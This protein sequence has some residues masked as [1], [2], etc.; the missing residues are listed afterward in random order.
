MLAARWI[1]GYNLRCV[2]RLALHILFFLSG[3]AALGYQLIWAK[4]FSTGLGHEYP[5]VLAIVCAFMV[6]M[7]LG[8]ATIDRFVPRDARAQWALA[9]LELIVGLWAVLA[10]FLI[11]H[12]NDWAPQ[13]IGLQPSALKHWLIAFAV[14]AVTLLPA[15]FSMGATLPVM[16]KLLSVTVDR[17]GSIGSIYAA[18]TFGAVLGTLLAPWLLMPALGFTKSCWVL[19]GLNVLVSAGVLALKVQR[20]A[21]TVPTAH[22][23]AESPVLTPRRITLTLFVAGLLGIS[24]EV[25][26]V[27][28]LSQ[29]MENTVYTYASIL[30]IF[31]LGTAAGAAAF[32]RW[33]RGMNPER[34]L[35]ALLI[36]ASAS[37]FLGVVAMARSSV[38]YKS[39]RQFGD[40]PIAILAAELLTALV[41]FGLPAFFMGATFSHLVQQARAVRG[42]IGSVVALNTIGAALAS[43][44]MFMLLPG[45]GT[46]WTLFAT[47][48]GYAAL[49]I[50][51]RPPK[52]AFAGLLFPIIVCFSDLRIV[53]VPP[54]SR[55]SEYRE[56]VMGTVAVVEDPS[57]QRTLRVD[58]RF[59]MGG[60]A[61][62]DAEYRQAHLP[63]LLHGAPKRALFLGLGTGISFGAAALYPDLKSDG[64]ELV[65]E[66][67]EVMPAFAPANLKPYEQPNLRLHVADARRFVRAANDS[68]DVIIADVFH[69]Y[70]DGAGA[71]YTEEHFRNVSRRLNPDGLFC[72]WLPL[73]Q[74]DEPTLRVIIRSFLNVFPNGEAWLLR[75]NVD[76]P[77]VALMGGPGQPSWSE[78]WVEQRPTD[79]R[80]G[81]ELKRLALADSVRLFG[82]LLADAEDLKTFA[83]EAPLN[84]DDNQ[85]VTFMAPRAAYRRD[86]KPYESLLVLLS[87]SKV[88]RVSA[89]AG[90]QFEAR[91]NKYIEARNIYLHGLIHDAERRHEA[92]LE[93]YLE[94]ARISGD[95]TSGYAQ[96]LNIASATAASEPARAKRILEQLIRAQ[97]ERPVAAEMLKRLFPGQGP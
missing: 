18:N 85:R 26:G 81:G 54:G 33:W 12:V 25:A 84:T 37:C 35:A 48:L 61:V 94:S 69:P 31:L 50:P 77:V 51:T 79:P 53:D 1:I 19:A 32:H 41:V 65:P 95:F 92:A 87:Q 63:L 96:C 7:T 80:L 88:R 70:R 17:G 42:R 57:G 38:I 93:A 43:A 6:G 58:N 36:A 21:S 75:F 72:Q 83:G 16:E 20:G 52:V 78:S 5:A 22:A 82:H 10:S 30:A 39:L 27:R 8:A 62:A 40:S 91:V 24:Y 28:V 90:T 60:T 67:V 64:V 86:A 34:L 44:V 66:V 47:A 23:N 59:Q 11:P 76:V 49:G 4:M 56:G 89:T 15:T 45:I 29:V 55:V 74:L 97:P 2:I 13:W 73:H 9:A 3:A 68:Y 14:P 46:K 71:L